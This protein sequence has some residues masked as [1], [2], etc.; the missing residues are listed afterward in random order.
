MRLQTPMEDLCMDMNQLNMMLTAILKKLQIVRVKFQVLKK[1]FQRKE[2]IYK[3]K[4]NQGKYIKKMK[5]CKM[6]K[7]L[8][9]M[10]R[11]KKETKY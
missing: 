5:F 4:K 9:K 3:V 10:N 6:I 8:I 1:N 7:Y 11:M 2:K